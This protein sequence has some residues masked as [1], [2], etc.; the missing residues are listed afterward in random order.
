MK[1]LFQTN[2]M[3]AIEELFCTD[4]KLF[5]LAKDIESISKTIIIP[6]GLKITSISFFNSTITLYRRP[7]VSPRPQS[8]A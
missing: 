3:A 1:T 5:A 7:S 4:F 8:N 2:N 6:N